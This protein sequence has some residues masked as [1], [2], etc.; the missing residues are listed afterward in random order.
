M[1]RCSS[2]SLFIN[3]LYPHLLHFSTSSM[4]YKTLNGERRLN[5]RILFS[6][7]SEY[8]ATT[9]LTVTINLLVCLLPFC[10]V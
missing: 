3:L 9:W 10:F 7:T 2:L 5:N 4:E 1:F 6:T 8:V